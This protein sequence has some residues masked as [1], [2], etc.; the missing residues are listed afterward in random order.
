MDSDKLSIHL[1]TNLNDYYW[2]ENLKIAL[3]Y[4][5][6]RYDTSILNI[7]GCPAIYKKDNCKLN[8]N[9][10]I[11]K[12]YSFF[13]DEGYELGINIQA[14]KEIEKKWENILT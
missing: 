6:L 4:N 14:V 5:I 9:L 2:K 8:G 12:A 1:H 11:V 7:G 3:K 13:K 10:N